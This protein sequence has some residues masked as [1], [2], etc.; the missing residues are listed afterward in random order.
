MSQYLLRLPQVIERTGYAR[1]SIFAAVKRGDFP[2]PIKLGP[3]A[4]A[5]PS[6]EVDA[7]VAARIAASRLGRGQ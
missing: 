5:W 6:D 7:W 1:A 3:R 2:K 4:I